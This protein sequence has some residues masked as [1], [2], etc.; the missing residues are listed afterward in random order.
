[1]PATAESL[2]SKADPM[3]LYRLR[4]ELAQ[5]HQ[6][7][8]AY[9]RMLV[10]QIAQSWLRL[11]RAAKLEQDYFQANDLMEVIATKLDQFKAVTRYASDCDRAWHK[12]VALLKT[13]QRQRRRDDLSSPNARRGPYPRVPAPLVSDRDSSNLEFGIKPQ[14]RE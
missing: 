13:A 1:M 5:I 7:A 12:A 8:N 11:Q 3:E 10:T 4:D 2:K 14:Q 9:E 6:P